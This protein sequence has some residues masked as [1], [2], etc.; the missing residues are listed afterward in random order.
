MSQKATHSK[1]P[2]GW[3]E[4]WE[5]ANRDKLAVQRHL[6]LLALGLVQALRQKRINAHDAWDSG[7][8]FRTYLKLKVRR[9]DRRLLDLWTWG[10]ELPQVEKLGDAA[11]AESFDAMEGLAAAVLSD[12]QDPHPSNGIRERLA[13]KGKRFT[14]RQIKQAVNHGRR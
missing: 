9:L 13:K 5:T 3:S 6:A 2:N 12:L 11:L 14:Q 4:I 10:M 1:S 7:L 8:K